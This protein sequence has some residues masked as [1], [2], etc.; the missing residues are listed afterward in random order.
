MADQDDGR[1]S[2]L[3]LAPEG[4]DVL[5]AIRAFRRKVVAG[6]SAHW[7]GAGRA[8]LADLLTRFVR[9]VAAVTGPPHG[10]GS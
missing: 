10:P 6:A 5:A 4:G 7:S 9:D 8:A 3:E 1:R 2:P